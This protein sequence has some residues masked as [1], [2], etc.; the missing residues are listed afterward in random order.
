MRVIIMV[1]NVPSWGITNPRPES[2][3]RDSPVAS[4]RHA[5]VDYGQNVLKIMGR[6][7]S[8][9]SSRTDEGKNTLSIQECLKGHLMLMVDGDG[10]IV[11]R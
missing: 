10:G 1:I 6:Y 5:P 7:Y 8:H 3:P 4:I 9:D 11:L 2:Q